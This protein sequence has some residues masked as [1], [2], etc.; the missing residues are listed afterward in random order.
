M[1]PD[2]LRRRPLRDHALRY[3]ALGALAALA[4]A[5]T[6]CASDASGGAE[7]GIAAAPPPP[8][9]GPDHH[10]EGR[11]WTLVWSDEFD[12]DALDPTKWAPEESCWGGGNEERQ[13]YTGRPENVQV[14]NGQLR[15]I[16]Q[17]ERFTGPDRPPEH[18][19]EG[20]RTR[21]YTSGKVRTRELAE[22]RYGRIAARMKLPD[23]Q[24]VWP[25]FWM[26]PAED[27]YG[28]WPLSG[29]IDI[30]E[31][32]N[33]GAACETCEGGR[34]NRIVAALHFGGTYPDNTHHAGAVTLPG[35]ADPADGFHVYALEWG[36]G[37]LQWLVDG[38]VYY[39]LDASD[40]F[41]A[42]PEGEGRPEA[43]FDRAF[44]AMFNLAVGGRWPENENEG[45]L[46]PD[47]LPA[48]LL[49]DW[50][51]VHQCEPDPDTGRA[52]MDDGPVTDRAEHLEAD[53]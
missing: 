8:P 41:T 53:P 14:V 35:G 18:E 37:R 51:R 9:E 27:H 26:M 44:Y 33:L 6:G 16:A 32:I 43:P 40:W 36:E 24:G 11:G 45:G 19:M 42:A 20:E 30:L 46:D 50:M 49:V 23:G 31:A 10:P 7:G 15:L 2:S 52:C 12:G 22:W 34:E 5:L 48:E 38:E 1:S 3:G 17:A 39:R 4:L 28:V 25:A 21:D 29:E 47:A 13:C